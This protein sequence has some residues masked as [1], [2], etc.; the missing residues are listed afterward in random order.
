MANRLATRSLSLPRS[1]HAHEVR[2]LI[3]ERSWFAACNEE[4]LSDVYATF[5]RMEVGL[6][7]V[8]GLDFEI[9]YI[10]ANPW[11]RQ[12]TQASLV[13]YIIEEDKTPLTLLP[14]SVEELYEFLDTTK[15]RLK[16]VR[17]LLAYLQ[18]KE[19]SDAT[20]EAARRLCAS[21]GLGEFGSS[22]STDLDTLGRGLVAVK[23]RYT[24]A[25]TR[26]SA[27]LSSPR[28][29]PLRG[30]F[31]QDVPTYEQPIADRIGIRL[32][33]YEGRAGLDRQRSNRRDAMNIATIIQHS[34]AEADAYEA[35]PEKYEGSFLRLLTNTDCLLKYPV[36]EYVDIIPQRLARTTPGTL[37]NIQHSLAVR[38][39][40]EACYATA[41]LEMFGPDYTSCR[42]A[43]GDLITK[44][45]DLQLQVD[46]ADAELSSFFAP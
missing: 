29:V 33:T 10:Y 5:Q 24:R 12:A 9:I 41:L 19:A 11:S 25:T 15:G 26:I 13:E 39:C 28:V 16:E 7:L 40:F 8:Y 45:K 2:D 23:E 43:A 14:G 44:A 18:K 27:L 38:S 37:S 22:S 32:S 17:E 6:K 36:N 42:K 46:Y 4:I 1:K 30:L 21:G 31:K 35:T 20:I 3:E 34:L